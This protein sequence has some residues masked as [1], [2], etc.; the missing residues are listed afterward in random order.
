MNGTLIT[1]VFSILTILATSFSGILLHKYTKNEDKID[2]TLRNIFKGIWTSIKFFIPLFILILLS[3]YHIDWNINFSIYLLICIVLFIYLIYFIYIPYSKF[4]S[5]KESRDKLLYDNKV[6]S[7]TSNNDKKLKDQLNNLCHN[8]PDV[9]LSD[10]IKHIEGTIDIEKDKLE[11]VK[12]FD[13]LLNNK[14]N[15]GSIQC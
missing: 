12:K 3:L 5:L 1:I 8:V 14:F 9:S 10:A 15:S 6:L 13:L 2:L 4:Q 11:N 7:E